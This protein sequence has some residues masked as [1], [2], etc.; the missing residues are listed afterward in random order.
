M[1]NPIIVWILT[2]AL[3]LCGNMLLNSQC[4]ITGRTVIADND[5]TQL[6]ILV[7][8]LNEP[9]LSSEI[10][11]LCAVQIQFKHQVIGDISATLYSPDGDSVVLIGEA[12]AASPL[13][14]F[15]R[16]NV[17]FV[18][19]ELEAAP[20]PGFSEVWFN[21]Q[22]WGVF[23]NYSGQYYPFS[24]CLED[25]YTGS[26]NGT[27]TLRIID[28]AEFDTGEIS[29]IQLIFC[30]QEGQICK[31]CQLDPGIT[32]TDTISV[33]KTN[34]GFNAPES[35]YPL[36]ERDTTFYHYKWAVFKDT[37]LTHIQDEGQW[38]EQEDGLYRVCGMQ[39][40]K[41]D[42]LK[43]PVLPVAGNSISLNAQFQ[44]S[45]LCAKISD[46]CFYVWVSDLPLDT[47]DVTRYLC[48][49]QPVTFKDSVYTE[50]G[51]YIVT[52]SQG[53]CDS[54]FRLQVLLSALDVSISLDSSFYPSDTIGCQGHAAGLYIKTTG[55]AAP[56]KTVSWFTNDGFIQSPQNRDTIVV[57]TEGTYYV[58]AFDGHC[59]DTSGYVIYQYADNP[60]ITLDGALLLN[61]VTDT[62]KVAVNTVQQTDSVKW[63]SY[64]PF[65]TLQSQLM[66]SV[67]G[68]YLAEVYFDNGCIGAKR[69]DIDTL[70]TRPSFV[71]QGDTIRCGK[72]TAMLQLL[73]ISIDTV[74]VFWTD[75]VIGTEGNLS[76]QATDPGW[77]YVEVIHNLSSCFAVD[78]FFV[79]D[80]RE[81]PYVE[82]QSDTLNCI[83]SV[84]SP[85]L[86]TNEDSLDYEW[87]GP[88]LFSS[89][90]Q[91]DI[92]VGGLYMLQVTNPQGCSAAQSFEVYQDTTKPLIILERV[93]LLDC[94]TKEIILQVQVIDSTIQYTWTDNYLPNPVIV[95]DPGNYLVRAYSTVNGCRDS[96][97]AEVFQNESFAKYNVSITPMN[98][99]RDSALIVVVPQESF[100]QIEWSVSNPVVFDV[101][102]LTASTDVEGTYFF[103][104]ISDGDCIIQDSLV[105]SSDTLKPL[106]LEVSVRNINCYSDTAAVVV[107]W[108]EFPA[109]AEWT[110]EGIVY[111]DLVQAL[112]TSSGVIGLSAVGS[113]GCKFDSLFTINLDTLRPVFDIYY[114]SLNCFYP[115]GIAA[116][117]LESDID[118]ARW[119]FP[120]GT[121]VDGWDIVYQQTGVYTVSVTGINGCVAVKPFEVAEDFSLPEFSVQDFYTLGCQETSIP[122]S[123]S[124]SDDIYEVKWTTS[125]GFSWIQN[126]LDIDEEGM[127]TVI[128]TGINGCVDSSSFLVEKITDTV[129][130]QVITDTLNC[131]RKQIQLN[132]QTSDNDAMIVW[133]TSDGTII[134]GNDISISEGGEFSVFIIPLKLCPDSLTFE[135]MQDTIIPRF[136]IEQER[137]LVC[138]NAL[139]A[140]EI[141]PE[142]PDRLFDAL[143]TTSNGQI[144]SGQTDA[145]VNIEGKGNYSVRIQDQKNGCISEDTILVEELGENLTMADILVGQPLCKNAEL[146]KISL[147]V[148]DGTAPYAINLNGMDF[149]QQTEF[150]GLQPGSYLITVKDS[151]GC[152]L[153]TVIQMFSAP[154]LS[155][156]LEETYK[157]QFGDTLIWQPDLSDFTGWDYSISLLERGQLVCKDTCRLPFQISPSRNT[158]Y[159][160]VVTPANSVCSFRQRILVT[161]DESLFSGIPNIISFSAVEANNDVFYIPQKRGVRRIKSVK[162]FD[163]WG[164]PVFFRE[165]FPPGEPQFGWNG[166]IMGKNA[167]TGVYFVIVDFEL[168]DGRSLRYNGDVTLIP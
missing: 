106:P 44:D 130:F 38:T 159:E 8:G 89:E 74:S 52:L 9:D 63:F 48:G 150:A 122:V 134:T 140:L 51:N 39:Y 49:N 78:S 92:S 58:A 19:C 154:D 131:L 10:Q 119:T 20:D 116:I 43:L 95:N 135:V 45:L 87:T 80:I 129:L 160:I 133:E 117:E 46:T 127:Y 47:L 118:S 114:D 75:V 151:F 113:N 7:Q 128:V 136:I 143:W 139:T 107:E 77:K 16:W 132:V 148:L 61:C 54:V 108:F 68:I 27:W 104:V 84:V 36:Y 137:D 103:S 111:E 96:L 105:I 142:N 162:I 98:C 112:A 168:T 81:Y 125:Q 26:A 73:N 22:D 24:G 153:D 2:I 102:T 71:L 67:P 164:S 99:T 42:S 6:S 4:I 141:I 60:E 17:T 147:T 56:V 23:G 126:T 120:D 138:G 5:T 161:V 155:I 163:K 64:N 97:V 166:T 90:E 94:D 83:K 41:G 33:C 40:A 152:V 11:G 121:E 115:E 149:G 158:I 12:V 57:R 62:V 53:G 76:A 100:D 110:G 156:G 28:I 55:Q 32:A 123:I 70:Y 167:E 79:E 91:V 124:S 59:R 1:R 35:F 25:F 88:G 165:D 37:L 86:Y 146:G 101:G 3:L 157:V 93:G 69:V 18:A 31:A 50:P 13:T 14:D 15:T 109:T 34:T 85:V 30:D 21:D 66:T 144:L 65:D 72:D 29:G 145:I 82:I